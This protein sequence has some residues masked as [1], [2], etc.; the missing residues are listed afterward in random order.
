MKTLE[1]NIQKKVK[2]FDLTVSFQHQHKCLG[3]LGASGSGKSMILKCIAGIACP[4]QGRIQ[5]EAV[6]YDSKHKINVKPQKRK[7][8]YLFQDYALFEN[9]TIKQNIEVGMEKKNEIRLKALLK[10]FDIEQIQNQFPTK[11]SG[12]QKQRVALARLLASDPSILLFDE[13]TSALDAFL[14]EKVRFELKEII[15]KHTGV[16]ILVSHDRDEIYQLCEYVFVLDKG[17]ILQYGYTKDVFQHPTYL[18]VARLTG[19]KNISKIKKIDT[20]HVVALDWNCVLEVNETKEDIS[21]IG[22]RAHDFIPCSKHDKNCIKIKIKEVSEL[23]FEWEVLLENGL[24]WKLHKDRIDD[25][26]FLK[27]E[28][29]SI[30]KDSILLLK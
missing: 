10:R 4:D 3:I 17:K 25:A 30:S 14:K 27:V 18:Q 15:E 5:Y 11:I 19:C 13:P 23:P 8:G 26:Y 6:L 2:E 21:Y 1:V 29:L 20:K 24:W 16:S 9:M 12:G 22:I 7:I 28:Y